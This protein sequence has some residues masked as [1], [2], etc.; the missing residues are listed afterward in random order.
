MLIKVVLLRWALLTVVF[1][2]TAALHPQIKVRSWFTAAGAAGFFGLANLVVGFLIKLVF[3][4]LTLPTLGLIWLVYPV[5]ALIAN[6][7]LLQYLD[8][9][10][11]EKLKFITIRALLMTSVIMGVA[12]WAAFRFIR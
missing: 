7:V 8:D 9:R 5:A 3:W 12:T 4:L 10:F 11:G 6:A 2:I 1:G